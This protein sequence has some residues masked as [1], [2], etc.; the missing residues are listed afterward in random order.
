M[1]DGFDFKDKNSSTIEAG[2]L[3][4]T[5][6]QISEEIKFLLEDC[7]PAVWLCGEISGFKLYNSGHMYF[8]LKDAKSQIRAVMFQGE[9]AGLVFKPEDGMEVL[10]FGRIS[11]YPVRGDYQIIVTKMEQFGKGD[12]ALE[13]EKLKNK[14]EKEGLFDK[15]AK[16]EIP[17]IINR[18]GV[19]TSKDGAALRDILKVIESFDANIEIIVCHALVQGKEAEIDIPKAVNYLNDNYK[20]LDVLLVGRGGGSIQDLW[21]FNC[22][23]VVR[24]IFNS[25]IPTISCVGHETDWTIADFVADLRAPTPSAAA[26]MILRNRNILKE[27]LIYSQ[28]ILLKNINNLVNYYSE[29]LSAFS[30]SKVLIKPHLIYE[31]KISYVEDLNLELIKNTNRIFESKC[32]KFKNICHKLDIVSPLSVLKRGFSICFDRENKIIKTTKSIENGDMIKIR[33]SDGN[34][35]AEVKND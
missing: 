17:F 26:E 8:S 33:L 7:Y 13:F 11:S 15:S 19:V 4:Y 3:I 28:E 1:R 16:K 22:E 5:V 12:L 6:S 14:L 31:D 10:I 32:E 9:N 20:N 34:L 23:N 27:R 24:A 25:K 29:K 30:K 18:I 35:K 2:K 21:S